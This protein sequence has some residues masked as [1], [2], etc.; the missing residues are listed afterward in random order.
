MNKTKRIAFGIGMVL[1]VLVVFTASAVAHNVVYFVP[2][3]SCTEPSNTTVVTQ[4]MNITDGVASLGCDVY[5]DPDV[6]NITNATPG[7]LPEMWLFSHKG[8]WVRFGG[9]SSNYLDL[10]PGDYKLADL[11]LVANNTG[12]SALHFDPVWSLLSDQY[13]KTVP[14]TWNDGTFKCPCGVPEVIN[15]TNADINVSGTVSGNHTL[16]WGS[17]NVSESITEEVTKGKPSKRISRLEHKWTIDVISGTKTDVTFHVE[18]WHTENT[19]N[20]H[21]KFAYST[22][23]DGTY[24]PMVTVIK[25]SDNHEYQTYKLPNET[26]GIVYIRV[27]DTDRTGGNSTPDTIYID[28]MFIRS[29]PGPPDI[30]PPVITNVTN[31]APTHNSATIMWDTDEPS[32]S[33]VKYGTVS[34]SYNKSKSDAAYVT[35]HSIELTG[36]ESNTTYYYVVNSTDPSGN[37]NESAEYNFTTEP[38]PAMPDLEI[39]DIWCQFVRKDTYDIYYNITNNGGEEAGRSD[40]NWTIGSDTGTDKVASLAPGQTREEKFTYRGSAPSTVKVCAD[41][42]DKIVESDETNNCLEKTVT[43][44]QP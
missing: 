3:P 1:T 30:T 22:S 28:H 43:C 15:V 17:D 27:M 11:T 24:T 37:S 41:Y 32:D 26:S 18:A 29:V 2:D 7:D 38:K 13:G 35:S 20:D 5:F 10:P 42:N 4:R 31:T 34:G 16:T 14:A 9:W 6:V 21:F 23:L 33:L 19:E 8:N 25:T 39:T 44:T 36:L 12:T 40:S